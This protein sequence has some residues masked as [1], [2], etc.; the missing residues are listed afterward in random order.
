M[1]IDETS[2]MTASLRKLAWGGKAARVMA[3]ALA[4]ADPEA[5]V[6]RQLKR[7]GNILEVAGKV[8]DLNQ[9]NN[10]LVVGAGKAGALMLKAVSETLHDRISAGCVIV[11]RGHRFADYRYPHGVTVIEAGHPVPDD[12]G[13]YGTKMIIELILNAEERDLIICLISGGGSALLTSPVPEIS[14]ESIQTLTQDLLACGADI[15]EINTMRK[16][17]DLVKGGGIAWLAFP[18]H[19]VALILS[20]VVGDPL[21]IIASGPTVP[22]PGTYKD[23]WNVLTKYKLVKNT[24]KDVVRWLQ[25]GMAGEIADNPKPGDRVFRRVHNVVVGSNQQAIEFALSQALKEGFHPI[26]L[27][28]RLTGEARQAGP[29]LAAIARQASARGS[30]PLCM[31][32]GGETTVILQGNGLGGRNQELTLSAVKDLAGLS[33]VVIASLATDGGDG[34]TDAAGAVATGDTYDLAASMGMD[35]EE[36]LNRNDAYH[37]FEPLE[38]LLKTGPT[39]TNV[40]DITFLFI[41]ME[42]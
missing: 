10:V 5:S 11:K 2:L 40:N 27:T 1:R 31:V 32:A 20:D 26:L 42:E 22:D 28:S 34:P 12:D 39:L 35:P 25:K 37:F 4:G 17:L 36:Y 18:A 30:M 38:D 29:V 16:H 8:Y 24:R 19:L 3:S 14:L 21:D 23:A 41:E 7:K 13:V 9:F 15:N 6:E 33:N